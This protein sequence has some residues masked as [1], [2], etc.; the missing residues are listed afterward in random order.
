M[1]IE[2]N[3]TTNS[4][5]PKSLKKLL[6]KIKKHIHQRIAYWKYGL[7]VGGHLFFYKKSR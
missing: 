2:S 5:K 3:A 7:G 6:N 1:P 4:G